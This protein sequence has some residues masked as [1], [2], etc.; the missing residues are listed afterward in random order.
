MDAAHERTEP[1]GIYFFH[2]LIGN[3]QTRAIDHCK[4]RAC[5]NEDQQH[6]DGQ[7]AEVI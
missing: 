7:C 2:G 5:C 1:V 6:K 3:I 4:V